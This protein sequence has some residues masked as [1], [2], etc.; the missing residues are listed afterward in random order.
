MLCL[1]K[2][3]HFVLLEVRFVICERGAFLSSHNRAV[4]CAADELLA[5]VFVVLFGE[6]GVHLLELRVRRD[7]VGFHV[8]LL[9]V[10]LDQ[11]EQ[12]AYA[13]LSDVIVC[14]DLVDECLV[15]FVCLQTIKS[16]N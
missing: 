2:R 10:G 14:T 12:F 3:S 7:R 11:S 6:R 16:N 15:P 1:R 4:D 5:I 13:R 8:Q 9:S